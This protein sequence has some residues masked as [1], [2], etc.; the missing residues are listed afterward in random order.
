MVTLQRRELE[1]LQRSG[2]ARAPFLT[3][4]STED[5]EL[6]GLSALIKEA[7]FDPFTRQYKHLDLLQFDTS[8]EISVTMPLT[9]VGRAKGLELGGMMEVIKREIT[10]TCLAKDLP[11]KIEVD[12]SSLELGTSFKVRNISLGENVRIE[13]DADSALVAITLPSAAE[14]KA[15]AVTEEVVPEEV[16]APAE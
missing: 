11:H 2:L 12:V 14:P 1:D 5:K 10:I 16:A 15:V 4:R 7:Q 6:D 13:D 3:L 9:F 8:K